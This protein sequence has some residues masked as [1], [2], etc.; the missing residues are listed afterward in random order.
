MNFEAG[1]LTFQPN[2]V[3]LK[4]P[5]ML[6]TIFSAQGTLQTES[7]LWSNPVCTC[8]NEVKDGKVTFRRL[9]PICSRAAVMNYL[10]AGW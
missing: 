6:K 3:D 7:A 9:G 1:H 10:L 5:T 2:E 8:D 4:V